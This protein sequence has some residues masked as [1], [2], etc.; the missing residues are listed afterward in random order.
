MVE[1]EVEQDMKGRVSFRRMERREMT[2]ESGGKNT[3]LFRWSQDK[4]A[5][6]PLYIRQL[7]N[8]KNLGPQVTCFV[9]PVAMSV[10]FGLLLFHVSVS[11]FVK[12]VA[13]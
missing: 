9:L 5:L 8:G 1:E 4:M 10:N 3:E 11:P 6:M 13:S 12:W 2:M 7:H